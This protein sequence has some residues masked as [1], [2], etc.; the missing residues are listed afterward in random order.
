MKTDDYIDEYNDELRKFYFRYNLRFPRIDYMTL[1][2]VQVK[3][4]IESYLEYFVFE[5]FRHEYMLLGF[6]KILNEGFGE[7]AIVKMWKAQIHKFYKF[8]KPLSRYQ[9]LDEM[10]IENLIIDEYRRMKKPRLN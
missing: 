8:L 10:G 3:I 1:T 5:K 7:D 2:A 9:H 6:R 4:T